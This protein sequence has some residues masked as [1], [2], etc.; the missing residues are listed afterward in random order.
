MEKDVIK[1]RTPDGF[2]EIE[3]DLATDYPNFYKQFA[4]EHKLP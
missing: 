1:V 4:K 2:R 3:V